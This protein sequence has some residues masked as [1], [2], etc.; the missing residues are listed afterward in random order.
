MPCVYLDM[1]P[2]KRIGRCPF[3][4]PTR[5]A[6]IIYTTSSA[7]GDNLVRIRCNESDE[8]FTV[9]C[10]EDGECHLKSTVSDTELVNIL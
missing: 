4:D 1:V 9:E 5:P 10:G 2:L 6:S 7:G 8:I 3:L